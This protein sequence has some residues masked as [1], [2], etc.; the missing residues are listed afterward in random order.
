MLVAFAGYND[1]ILN[2]FQTTDP[3]NSFFFHCQTPLQL[4]FIS[5]IRFIFFLF[6]NLS[7]Y[8]FA[9][10]RPFSRQQRNK[11]AMNHVLTQACLQ[12]YLGHFQVCPSTFLVRLILTFPS[13][14]SS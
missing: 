9:S 12:G 3:F 6:H 2:E 13:F 14:P 11:S 7:S 4:D 1:E 5:Y 8:V 10:R